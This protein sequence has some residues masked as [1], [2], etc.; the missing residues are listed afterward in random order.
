MENKLTEMEAFA[1]KLCNE[2]GELS[3]GELGVL[4]NNHKGRGNAVSSRGSFGTTSAAYRA[5]R[6]LMKKGLLKSGG[7]RWVT[8][9]N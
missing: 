3:P 1:L 7:H 8:L 9:K 5:L 2:K 4:W 6:S